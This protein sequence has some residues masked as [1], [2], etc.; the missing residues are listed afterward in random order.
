VAGGGILGIIVA[1]AI[2]YFTGGDPTAALVEGVQQQM[3]AKTE[4]V[5]EQEFTAEEHPTDEE[6][7][8]DRQSERPSHK[9]EAREFWFATAPMWARNNDFIEAVSKA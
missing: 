4:T 7:L 5:G 3:Q 2:A 1:V 9:T 8:A 6:F